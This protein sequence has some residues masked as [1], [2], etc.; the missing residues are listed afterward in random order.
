M[1]SSRRRGPAE[2]NSAEYIEYIACYMWACHLDI[3]GH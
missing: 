2:N 1:S 3:I